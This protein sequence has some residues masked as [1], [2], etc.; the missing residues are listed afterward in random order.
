VPTF[1]AVS[2][3]GWKSLKAAMSDLSSTMMQ[4]SWKGVGGGGEEEGSNLCMVARL[5][6]LGYGYVI[7]S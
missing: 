4:S 1:S 3:E 5:L 6:F 7:V 2:A